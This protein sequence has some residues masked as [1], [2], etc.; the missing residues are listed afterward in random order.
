M[1]RMMCG[2]ARVAVV[3]LALTS[4]GFAA[5][6]WP[7]WRGPKLDALST[8]TGL[9]KEWPDGGP[10][11][12]WKMNGL[13]VGYSS[14]A[15]VGDRFYTMGDLAADGGRRQFLI[16]FDLKTRKE[17]WRAEVGPPHGDGSRCTPTVDD[18]LVYGI[19]SSGDL[20]CAQAATGSI[21][22]RKNFAK[23]FG[24]RMMSGWRYSESPLVDGE[25]LVCTP[26]G[27]DAMMAALNK[28]TGATLWK[29][30]MP[31]IGGRGKDGAG[32]SSIVISEGAGVR[33]Y[34][35][36]VGR[37]VISVRAADGKFLWGY[38]KV[39]NGVANIPTCVPAGDH[40]FC[41]SA[42]GTGSALLKLELK[43]DSVVAQEVY[44]L[45][46]R[47]F[48]N[49]HGGFVL[50]GDHIYGGHGHNAGT[51][52]CVELETGKVAWTGK[53]AGRGSAAV[54]YAD[55]HLIF[56]YQKS[57]VALFEATPEG[58]KLKGTFSTP[59][60]PGTRGNSWSHPVVHDGKLY[61]RH[62]DVLFCYD[63]KPR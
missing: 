18:G 44:F 5:T 22:W 6:D 9:L 38:N 23:D 53:Q 47:T 37:G 21:V 17:L 56:R 26:G 7:R 61:I 52:I 62:A 2:M 10:S 3:A 1:R 25:K 16:A 46:A 59:R 48:Q 27:R 30:A 39:A 41:S 42:Y 63:V 13:G 29:C 28:K 55:G 31:S 24:G 36:L 32:Y 11:L 20:V 54:L 19:G 15:I 58:C 34:V 14:I 57:E 45:D 33:Q 40:I 51:P 60:E 4:I 8:E 12:A 35:T 49:H 43:D 50:V